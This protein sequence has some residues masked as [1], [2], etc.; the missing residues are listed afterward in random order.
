MLTALTG[1]NVATVRK[2]IIEY[3][4]ITYRE[5]EATVV[6]GSTDINT[7]LHEYL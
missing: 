2:L 5:I 3:S 6:I 1:D 4:H 7:I